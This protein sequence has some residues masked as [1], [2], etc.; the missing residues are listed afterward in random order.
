MA[1]QQVQFN[2]E[3]RPEILSSGGLNKGFTMEG[4]FSR[5]QQI[6]VEDAD[7]GGTKPV[8]AY[9]IDT[10]GVETGIWETGKLK[11]LFSRVSLGS[12][13]KLVYL[14]KVK[15]TSGKSKGRMVHDY[16]LYFELPEGATAHVPAP[17]QTPP[18]APQPKK[19]NLSKVG[20]A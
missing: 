3:D 16:E 11:A 18:A 8:T 14:G 6:D 9:F 17:T 1:Y 19:P 15:S 5:T 7:N 12:K 20:A 10:D 2:T 13:L 4:I